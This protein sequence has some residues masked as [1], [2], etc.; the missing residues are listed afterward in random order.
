MTYLRSQ[1]DYFQIGLNSI[2]QALSYLK[3]IDF[4]KTKNHFLPDLKKELKSSIDLELNEIIISNLKNTNIPIL[5]EESNQHN[6]NFSEHDGKLWIIDPL[7]GTFNF[8]RGLPFSTVSIAL[9]SGK[10]PLFSFVGI[11][12]GFKLGF[13]N[14]DGKAVF[15]NKQISVSSIKKKDE[16]VICT[17]IPSRQIINK[18]E[19]EIFLT[20]FVTFSKVRMLGSAS[21]SLLQLAKGSV[22]AYYEREIMIWD[23]AAGLGLV[24]AAGGNFE[25]YEGKQKN[26]LIVSANNSKIDHLIK[27]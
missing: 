9:Y 26:S 14:L 4:K 25:F 16:A 7:D 27:Y 24:N 11:I 22:D 6:I 21:Y 3:D 10:T 20:N 17:G 5:S 19:K 2:N 1:K 18:K 15:D 12:P 23:V 8:V 13:I